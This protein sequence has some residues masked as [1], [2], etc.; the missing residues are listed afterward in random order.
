MGLAA[1]RRLKWAGVAVALAWGNGYV[2]AQSFA[3]A[4]RA[5][6]AESAARPTVFHVNVGLRHRDPRTVIDYVLA[7]AQHSD[8]VV[9]I[10]AD[11]QC[12]NELERLRAAYPYSARRL[13]DTPY[14]LAVFSRLK[15]VS[16]AVVAG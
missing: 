9:L 3:P 4:A 16:S 1:L 2:V 10:E 7:N 15:P 6:A 8:V 12:E 11:L 5:G 13:E 14:G